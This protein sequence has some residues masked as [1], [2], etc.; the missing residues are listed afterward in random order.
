MKAL[1]LNHALF[2]SDMTETKCGMRVA[3]RAFVPA[4]RAGSGSDR[5]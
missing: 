3:G 2:F 5:Q 4:V 1:T